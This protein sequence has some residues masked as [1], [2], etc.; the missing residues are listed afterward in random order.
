MY[1]FVIFTFSRNT[2]VAVHE[3]S[4][5]DEYVDCGCSTADDNLIF[6]VTGWK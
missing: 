5:V 1:E 2:S 6:S 4:W 3:F